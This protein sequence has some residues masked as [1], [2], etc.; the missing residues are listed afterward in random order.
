MP[1][2]SNKRE[3][4]SSDCGEFLVILNV[5]ITKD[6]QWTSQQIGHKGEIKQKNTWARFCE[7]CGRVTFWTNPASI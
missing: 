3:C 2:I 4:G 6:V 5:Q 7:D 1:K